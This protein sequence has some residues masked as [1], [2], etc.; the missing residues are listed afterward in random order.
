MEALRQDVPD[1]LISDIG[2]PGERV[3][4]DGKDQALPTGGRHRRSR[5]R[6]I[7]ERTTL[8]GAGRRFFQMHAPLASP[9][10]SWRVA[11]LAA[12]S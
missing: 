10:R 9:R 6:P 5:S 8:Q 12:R 1:V 11:V 4:V 7:R 2:L 3:R